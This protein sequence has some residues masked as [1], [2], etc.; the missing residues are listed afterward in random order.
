MMMTAL[1]AVWRPLLAV[2]A[3]LGHVRELKAN[4][5]K[6]VAGKGGREGVHE[7]TV[8]ARAGTMRQHD[9]SFCILGTVMD[10]VRHQVGFSS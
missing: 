10:Q 7:G 4:D 9:G 3:T 5:V 6:F 1:L 2:F 8:H